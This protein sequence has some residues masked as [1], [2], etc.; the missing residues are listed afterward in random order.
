MAFLGINRGETWGELAKRIRP[1]IEAIAPIRSASRFDR[2]LQAFIK[3]IGNSPAS[4]PADSPEGAVAREALRD[5]QQMSFILEQLATFDIRPDFRARFKTMLND[6]CLPQQSPAETPGRDMQC[7]LYVEAIAQRAGLAPRFQ[8]PPDLVCNFK[9]DP[10]AIAVKRLKSWDALRTRV[11]SAANQ[12]REAGIPGF[13]AL[14]AS[15]ALN[16][17]NAYIPTA[18][19]GAK[20][21]ALLHQRE[22]LIWKNYCSDLLKWTEGK[23][24]LGLILVDHHVHCDPEKRWLLLSRMAMFDLVPHNKARQKLALDFFEIVSTGLGTQ[25]ERSFLPQ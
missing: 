10:I 22:L 2:M 14:D 8:E 3:P 16:K 15:R 18:I 24:V 25:A 9:G 4:F 20:R 17:E 19:S 1:L 23:W 13:I 21:T 6:A 11:K 12:I 7:E 5:L